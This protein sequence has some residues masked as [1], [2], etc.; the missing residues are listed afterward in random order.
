MS[1]SNDAGVRLSGLAFALSAY[2]VWG[3][4]P[5][6][7]KMLDHVAPLEVLAYRI[8]WTVP[9]VALVLFLRTQWA[10]VRDAL[11]DPAQL[12][13]LGTSAVLIAVNWGVYIWAVTNDRVLEA[14][15]GYF[16]TPLVSVALG[17]VLFSERLR[18]LQW[19]AI[20]LAAAG[21]LQLLVREGVLPWVGLAV[22]FS[23]GL[24]GG[25]RKRAAVESAA[26]LFI[27]TLLLMP[28]ALLW[29]TWLVATQS[30]SFMVVDL[31]TDMLLIG[32]GVA[33][34]VPLIFYVAAA[35]RLRLST[36]GVLFY[37]TPT[38]QF[39][40]GTW[41]YGEPLTAA[42]LATFVLIW[43]GLAIHFGEGRF[44]ERRVRRAAGL[45]AS[46]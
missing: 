25:L 26:G 9:L 4:F 44:H 20:G 28:L 35:R 16:M 6:Y 34:A 24:Y 37:L 41:L 13:L 43:I 3:L 33:T 30:G 19:L 2:V 45:E 27:E 10:P 39:G 18:P 29:I 23:F 7:F 8:V 38:I 11:R 22:A 1:D 14:S 5:L 31:Q 46:P 12:M 40:L 36:L 17:I 21:V 32:A 15:L 42:R